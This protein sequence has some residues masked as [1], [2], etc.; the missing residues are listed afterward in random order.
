M[1]PLG[2]GRVCY[3]YCCEV[4]ELVAPLAS[5]KPSRIE[6]TRTYLRTLVPMYLDGGILHEA[7]AGTG[8]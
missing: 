6:R 1:A 8:D 2:I 4:W 3:G 5:W 7:Y